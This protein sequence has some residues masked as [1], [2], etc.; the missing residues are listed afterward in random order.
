MF[1]PGESQGWGRLVGCHLWGHIESDMTEATNPWRAISGAWDS[2]CKVISLST[3]NTWL[4]SPLASVLLRRSLLSVSLLFLSGTLKIVFFKF[5]CFPIMWISF[6]LCFL[7]LSVHLQCEDFVF[8][9]GHFSTVR[10]WVFPAFT[11][12]NSYSMHVGPSW[13]ISFYP[14]RDFVSYLSLF[15]YLCAAFH[16]ISSDVFSSSLFHHS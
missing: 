5:C 11:F 8:H 2:W 12:W 3:W 13:T 1:L 7:R 16:E 14:L 15:L 9:S 4:P 10:S 6:Y